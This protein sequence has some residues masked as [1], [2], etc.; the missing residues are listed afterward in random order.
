MMPAA[1]VP[2]KLTAS[3]VAT[4]AVTAAIASAATG[5]A[6]SAISAAVSE[7]IVTVSATG[8]S[9]TSVSRSNVGDGHFRPGLSSAAST[10][11]S[12]AYTGWGVDVCV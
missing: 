10:S 5:A 4:G 2:A 7:A 11:N 8:D 3:V 9:T 1:G 6:V 12:S